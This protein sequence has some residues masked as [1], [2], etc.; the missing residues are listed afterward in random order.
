F[1]MTPTW[2]PDGTLIVFAEG[3]WDADP[4]GSGEIRTTSIRPGVPGIGSVAVAKGAIN[5]S[6]SPNG[7]EVVFAA[8]VPGGTAVFQD[9]AGTGDAS[10]AHQLTQGTDD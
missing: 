6:W 2:S 8:N 1:E 10:T 4:A 3:R 5:P 7:E 9:A